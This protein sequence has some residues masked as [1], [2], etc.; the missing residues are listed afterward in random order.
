MA[1]VVSEDDASEVVM[2]ELRPETLERATGHR[3]LWSTGDLWL[4]QGGLH[5]P[6]HHKIRCWII[7]FVHICLGD[8]GTIIFQ[9]N[10]PAAGNSKIQIRTKMLLALR[11]VFSFLH[12]LVF[13]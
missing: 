7:K 11:V 10:M 9:T 2:F 8:R 6:W 4:F 3:W 1:E 5:I 13:R 12:F